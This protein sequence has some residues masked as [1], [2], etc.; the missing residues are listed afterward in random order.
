M[1]HQAGVRTVVAGG[2]PEL[3]PMQA[4]GRSR[5]A[6]AYDAIALDED[7][8]FA[9]SV[10][11]SLVLPDRSAGDYVNYASFNLKDS[12]RQGETVPLQFV[13][14][15]ATCR[16]FYTTRTVYNYLNLWNYVVD[17]IWRNPSLCI[18]GAANGT[19]NDNTTGPAVNDKATVAIPNSK[20]PSLILSGLQSGPQYGPKNATNQNSKRDLP[21]PPPPPPSP[22]TPA[23]ELQ[24]ID[25]DG[26]VNGNPCQVCTRN[27]YTC[28]AVPTCTL[29]KVVTAT[30]ATAKPSA[31]SSCVRTCSQRNKPC[32]KTELCYWPPGHA[33]GF[34][35]ANKSAKAVEHCSSAKIT[36]SKAQQTKAVGGGNNR[37]PYAKLAPKNGGGQ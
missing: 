37:L 35:L 22:T 34:C 25:D 19:I 31:S 3:G 8:E 2:R 24:H 9:G 32:S 23:L 18:A 4:V 15:P 27:G 26:L 11:K 21:P 16:I 10:D 28:T 12:V 7:I 1:H 29:G 36:T 14:Q 20:I 33:Q 17:A 30:A 13:Y 6:E 5:G